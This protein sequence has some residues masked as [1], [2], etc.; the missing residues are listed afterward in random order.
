MPGRDVGGVEGG[1]WGEVSS[2]ANCTDY[3]A[4]RFNLR[5]RHGHK[6]NRFAHTLNGT[7]LAVPRVMLALLETHQRADG[8]VG[9]P[10]ALT[11]FMGGRAELKPREQSDR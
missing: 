1:S 5:Y 11:P 3:Q 8:S 7:A 2:T 4:R 10:P 6:D 9:L